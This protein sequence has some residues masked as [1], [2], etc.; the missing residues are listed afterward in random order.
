M[1]SKL[2]KALRI[3]CNKLFTGFLNG[4]LKKTEDEVIAYSKLMDNE[5]I[6]EIR[7]RKKH[8]TIIANDLCDGICLKTLHVKL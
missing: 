7:A 3:H 2:E 1:K 6:E 4:E 8:L 5:S